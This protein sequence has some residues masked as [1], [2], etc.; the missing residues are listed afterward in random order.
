MP[1]ASFDDNFPAV[2]DACALHPFHLRTTLFRLAARGLYRP[3]WSAEI[4]AELRRSLERRGVTE[5]SITHT[6][7]RMLETFPGA[8]IDS[9]GHLIDQ[10]TCDEKDRHVLAAAVKAQADVIVT[11]NLGDFPASSV[12]PHQ[13]EAQHPDEF[14][15]NLYAL[16]PNSVVQELTM[17]ADRNTEEPRTLDSLLDALARA[18]VPDFAARVRSALPPPDDN[19]A[20]HGESPA[21]GAGE[22]AP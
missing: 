16:R 1:F 15:L 19:R 9:Y 12:E 7:A 14:L 22:S 18:S 2:L 10:M 3:L 6:E 13:I 11:F 21:L 5:D 4:L 17:Q 8:E 20:L